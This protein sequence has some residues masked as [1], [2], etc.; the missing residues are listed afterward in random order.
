VRREVGSKGNQAEVTLTCLI[1]GVD[2][3][4]AAGLR[5]SGEEFRRPGGAIGR[6]KRGEEERILGAIYRHG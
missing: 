2:S 4:L 5:D 3:V 6:G 1:D